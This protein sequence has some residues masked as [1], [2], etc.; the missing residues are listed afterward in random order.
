M[1][2]SSWMRGIRAEHWPEIEELLVPWCRARDR[3]EIIER[4]QELRIRAAPVLGIAELVD[5]EHVR[6]RHSVRRAHDAHGEVVRPAPPFRL[7]SYAP[8]A[9]PAPRRGEHTMEIRSALGQAK[10]PWRKA[11]GDPSRP[12][13]SAGQPAALR[14]PRPRFH[15]RLGGAGLHAHPGGPRR[16]G[17]QA[18]GAEPLRS[19]AQH[20]PRRQRQQRRLLGALALLSE[21]QP[22][23]APH[24]RRPCARGGA[25]ARTAARGEVRRRR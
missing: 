17:D 7:R 23:Q 25:E 9:E 12:P 13:S 22:G 11:R 1:S 24:R 15:A 2:P 21:P 5:H 10:Q 8:R 14:H 19:D 16:R 18:G 20:V 4:A 6:H 3:D